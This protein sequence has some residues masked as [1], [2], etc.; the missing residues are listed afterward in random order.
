M[1][2]FMSNSFLSIVAMPNDKNMLC[3]RARAPKDIH[4]VFPNV[5][6]TKTPMRDYMY[7]AFIN[8]MIVADAIAAEVEG[9]TATNFKDSVKDTARH[10]AYFNVW[11]AMM[12]YQDR[13]HFKPPA[14]EPEFDFGSSFSAPTCEKCGGSG[15][16]SKGAHYRGSC[17]SCGGSGYMAL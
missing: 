2:I 3:V 15:S 12:K 5:K 16:Y 17:N 14:E 9:I 10:G 13:I 8:R 11:S 7:R 1:W 6:I 4:A